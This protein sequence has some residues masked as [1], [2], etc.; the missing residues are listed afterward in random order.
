MYGNKVGL[1]INK[2]PNIAANI[3]VLYSSCL[4]FNVYLTP[5]SFGAQLDNIYINSP[6]YNANSIKNSLGVDWSYREVSYFPPIVSSNENIVLQ[7]TAEYD[8]KYSSTNANNE[9]QFSSVS[10]SD[11][12]NIVPAAFGCVEDNVGVYVGSL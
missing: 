7:S 1:I 5:I 8:A 3:K 10:H 2:S 12:G 4:T 6:K 9:I 11:V